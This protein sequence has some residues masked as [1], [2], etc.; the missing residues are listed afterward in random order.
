MDCI[1]SQNGSFCQINDSCFRVEGES[2]EE[3]TNRI[4]KV[5]DR[6]ISSNLK[7]ICRRFGMGWNFVSSRNRKEI[8]CNCVSRK[9][10]YVSSAIRKSLS[11]TYGCS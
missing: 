10:S 7:E 9:I 1:D 2:V 4:C 6:F 3:A 11:I 8:S 5:G